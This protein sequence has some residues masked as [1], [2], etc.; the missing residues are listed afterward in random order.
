M[1]VRVLVVDDNLDNAELLEA[2]LSTRGHSI[3]LAHDGIS[4]LARLAEAPADV[5]F[6]DI[7]LEGMDG[8]EAA[9]AIRERFGSTVR[10]VA[11]TGFS[12]SEARR[13]A[14]AAGFDAFVTKPFDLAAVLAAVG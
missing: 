8:Y 5:V 1:S 11:V 4:A 13:R 7:G 6:L 12:G 3:R 10:L 9:A 14:A 2:V